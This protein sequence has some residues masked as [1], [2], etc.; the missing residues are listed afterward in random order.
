[1]A[2]GDTARAVRIDPRERGRVREGR[3][4][5]TLDS[6]LECLSLP[7]SPHP[8][9]AD[10]SFVFLVFQS[11]APAAPP[12]FPFVR[13]I[14]RP[15]SPSSLSPLRHHPFLYVLNPVNALICLRTYIQYLL[16]SQFNNRNKRESRENISY[17]DIHSVSAQNS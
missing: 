16:E 2:D 7:G 1:M 11:R 15:V 14:Y 6:P 5:T 3:V 9:S 12:Y 8:S 13:A 4:S 10:P 17:L